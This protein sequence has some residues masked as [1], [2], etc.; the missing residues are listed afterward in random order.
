MTYFVNLT[1]F[2]FMMIIY[3]CILDFFFFKLHIFIEINT[4]FFFSPETAAGYWKWS[5]SCMCSCCHCISLVSLGISLYT[6]MIFVKN[7][8]SQT[9]SIEL[10]SNFLQPIMVNVINRTKYS[11]L[12]S[13]KFVMWLPVWEVLV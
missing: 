10:F 11:S 1:N 2:Y 3:L 13:L 8:A 5:W 7:R 9:F 12:R 6:S 4:V